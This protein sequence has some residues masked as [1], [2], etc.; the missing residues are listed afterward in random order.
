MAHTPTAA[1]RR[2]PL[3]GLLGAIGLHRGTLAGIIAAALA[4]VALELVLPLL[5][6]DAIDL[7]TGQGSGG[8]SARLVT[9]WPALTVVITALIVVAL[10]R[11]AVQFL[12]R[13][14]SGRL[15]LNVQ[16]DLRQRI[17]A[18]LLRLDGPAQDQIRTGQ[19]VSRAIS[20]LGAVQG[21]LG[22]TPMALTSLIRLLGTLAIMLV[23]SPALSLVSVLTIPAMALII[24]V[25][26]KPLFAATWS[27]QQQAAEV[28]THVEE[29]VTGI[30]IVKAFAQERRE[31]GTIEALSRSLY[32]LRMR[33]A[34][35]NARYQPLLQVLPQAA[36]VANVLLGGWLALRG[37]ITIGTFVAFATYLTAITQLSRILAGF[38]STLQLSAA[39]VSRVFDIIDTDPTYHDPAHPRPI[40]DGPLGL[41][42]NDVHFSDGTHH[43]LRGLTFTVP[44]GSTTALIGP[45]G[46]GKSMLTQL[47]GGFYRPDRGDIALS[48]TSGSI[49]LN[50][51]AT[52]ELR[53][54]L[55]VSPDE[56]F[57]FSASIWDNIAAG[58][59]GATDAEVRAAA[60]HAQAADFIAQL[61]DGYDTVVGERGLTLS[62]GQRQRIALARALVARPRILVLDDATSAIDA[63]TERALIEALATHYGDITML[64]IAH[65]MSTVEAAD[66][67]V[68]VDHGAAVESGPLHEVSAHSSRFAGLMS[69]AE[70]NREQQDA[71]GFVDAL[72]PRNWSEDAAGDGPAPELMAAGGRGPGG[73]GRSF[74]GRGF[75]GGGGGMG[76]G[77]AMSAA[78]AAAPTPELLARVDALPPA[79]E[80]PALPAEELIA[81]QH[82]FS[83][84]QLFARVRWLIATVIA[85]LLLTAAL[86]LVFPALVRHAIDVGVRTG[87]AAALWQAGAAGLAVVAASWLA[88]RWNGIF[89]ART[90]ERLLY[91]LRVRSYAHL[92]RLG[93]DYF[94]RNLS[95][96]IMTRMT[97]DIDALSSFL[98]TALAQATVAAATL[99]GVIIMLL[100]TAPQL[101]AW[102]LLA[103]PIIIV[104]TLVFRRVSSRLYVKSRERISA[105]N[106]DFQQ[107]ISGLRT[108]QLHGQQQQLASKFAALSRRYVQARLQAQAAASAYF[109]GMQAISEITQAAI[110]GLGAGLIVDKQMTPGTLIAFILYLGMLFGPIQQLSQVFDSY[111][112]A[113]VSFDRISELL[114]TQSSV[115]NTGRAA[116]ES[117]ASG[118]LRLEA[119][120]FSYGPGLPTIMGDLNVTLAPGESVALVG[121][122][123]AGKSTIVKLLARFHD[124]V[125]GSVQAGGRDIRDFDLAQWRTQLGYVPQEPHLFTG[126]IATNIAYG[127]PDASEAEITEAAARIGALSVLA[128][129]PGGMHHRVSER[130]GGLSSG[131]R[132]IIAL[133]RAELVAPKIMLLDEAT[134]TLD[135]A[136]ESAILSASKR[137][138][139][140]RTS[141]IVAH[142][143]ATAAA[144]DR[145]LVIV[146]GKVVEDGSHDQLI[147]LGG[148]YAQLWAAHSRFE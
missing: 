112:Q 69:G 86:D 132:Q 30:R 49:G 51:V 144:A 32:A 110:L 16:H 105:V 46:S 11:W 12:R 45:P 39:S 37:D 148:T 103:L 18:S 142:R 133:A 35:L 14:L 68:I 62:G 70:A 48:T 87:Q 82:Q 97:T 65:R 21:M 83:L 81:A 52:N 78:L 19:V 101:A 61:P 115:P 119:V 63:T 94:E 91:G 135:P 126:T 5:T 44:A 22:M 77:S 114:A 136:T 56:A 8:L 43:I 123:G 76:R 42:I 93:L 20:D 75:G 74:G 146:G 100:V 137:L 140:G 71:A 125:A 121:P 138:V 143:L 1:P 38:I 145:I 84:R 28:A 99:I 17:L 13:F 27:A 102:A 58:R 79:T 60:E 15:S 116:V 108:A 80:T 129:I 2:S 34:K 106:A 89:T 55:T 66:Q 47:L 122:T 36:L 31:T 124:P 104:A 88:L 25:S 134:A 139:G 72:W 107:S 57:L 24:W 113:T 118:P 95:G 10:T 128:D 147:A 120:D 3:R 90:G 9:A 4:S 23:L 54:V 33:V 117:A 127:R 64:L 73:G 130:G 109:P 7:A 6:R 98:Q 96:A 141:V 92:Q 131:Q 40:P 41:A 50:D 85:L 53:S 111:Q 67:V 26:Q 59:T 29:T